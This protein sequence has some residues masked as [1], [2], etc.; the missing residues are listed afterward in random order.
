MAILA[1]FILNFVSKGLII[2]FLKKRLPKV[3]DILY[4]WP[5]LFILYG[6]MTIAFGMERH[7][8][9]S[10]SLTIYFMFL[11]IFSDIYLKRFH[12]LNQSGWLVMGMLVPFYNIYLLYRLL[13]VDGTKGENKYGPDPLESL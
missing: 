4:F 11:V 5:L 3:G 1:V 9:S 6:F 13:L 10:V 2:K 8:F 7:G 12:D